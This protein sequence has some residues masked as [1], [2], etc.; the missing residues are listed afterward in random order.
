MEALFYL[1]TFV[2]MKRE[3]KG[4]VLITDKVH[5]LLAQGLESRGYTV[6]VN[7][8][9]T[10][11]E[12]PAIIG[13]YSG[14]VINSKIIMNAAMMDRAPRLKFIARL[15]SGMEIVDQEY[16]LKQGIAVINTPEGNRDSVA[17]HAIGMLLALANN[18]KQSDLEVRDF[19]WKR[20]ANR[21]FELMGKTLGII[22]FGNTGSRLALKLSS[23][24][25]N[26]IFHDINPNISHQYTE[27]FESVS[28]QDIL[29]RADIIS[30]HIPWNN[31]T[32]HYVDETFISQCKDGMILIN[33][34]RGKV[35][36]TK[37]LING[38]KSGKLGGACLDVFENEKPESY[39]DE[40]YSMYSELFKFQN[41][42]LSPHVAGWTNESLEKIAHFVLKKLDQKGL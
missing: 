10:I 31:E 36:S 19:I 3:E 33:A 30:L 32:H 40:E 4:K 5:N 38:L 29:K 37:A 23:W 27:S 35:V 15:G 21:G 26:I 9:I 12:L 6:D 7:R 2:L 41:T 14:I 42:I 25:L 8:A 22:G 24:E 20:E 34:A 16:A 18:L 28:K 17:E 39:R 13:Q 1:G 11:Q